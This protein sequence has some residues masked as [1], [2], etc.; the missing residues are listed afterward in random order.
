MRKLYGIEQARQM[1]LDFVPFHMNEPTLTPPIIY[2]L[3]AFSN[4]SFHQYDMEQ[5]PTL[6]AVLVQVLMIFVRIHSNQMGCK[7]TR[8]R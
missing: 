8:R 1:R 6:S 2:N 5:N 4:D 7:K 3:N